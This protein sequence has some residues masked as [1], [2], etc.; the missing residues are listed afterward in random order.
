LSGIDERGWN[1]SYVEK[2]A[3]LGSQVD[4]AQKS[5]RVMWWLLMMLVDE[6]AMRW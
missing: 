2:V 4:L 6:T 1:I 3:W 5:W